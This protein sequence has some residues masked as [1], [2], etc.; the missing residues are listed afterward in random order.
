ME[1]RGHTG[2][3]EKFE[4]KEGESDWRRGGEIIGGSKKGRGG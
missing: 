3:I 4:W 1:K 2:G